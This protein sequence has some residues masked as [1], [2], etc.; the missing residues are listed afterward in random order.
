[1]VNN[2]INKLVNLLQ[3]KDT[4]GLK[5]RGSYAVQTGLYVGELLVYISESDNNYNFLSVPKMIN[6]NIPCSIFNSGLKSKIVEF[7]EI[8]PAKIHRVCQL[9]YLKNVR[10]D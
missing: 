9:Q 8:I 6:R 1:M 7:V 2:T 4:Q 10:K 3:K 5:F